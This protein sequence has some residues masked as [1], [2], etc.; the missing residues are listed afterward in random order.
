MHGSDER[1]SLRGLDIAVSRKRSRLAYWCMPCLCAYGVA[2]CVISVVPLGRWV[3][4]TE[5]MYS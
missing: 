1:H 4:L 3:V 5:Y 2:T